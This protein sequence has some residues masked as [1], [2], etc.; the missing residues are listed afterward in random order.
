MAAFQVT[1]NGQTNRFRRITS[2]APLRMISKLPLRNGHHRLYN[3]TKRDP[4]VSIGIH[5]FAVSN[6]TIYLR[7]KTDLE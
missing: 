6:L 4:I 7:V 5:K 3:F 1:K 2:L